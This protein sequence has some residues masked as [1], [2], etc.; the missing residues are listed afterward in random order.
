MD[1]GGVKWA[2]L[3]AGHD[4]FCGWICALAGQAE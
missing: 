4:F 1:A 3:K 2:R